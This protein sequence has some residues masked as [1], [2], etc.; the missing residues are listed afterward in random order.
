MLHSLC[1]VLLTGKMNWT[2]F[3]GTNRLAPKAVRC[4]V[5]HTAWSGLVSS[6]GMMPSVFQRF[7][8]SL[9]YWQREVYSPR[10]TSTGDQLKWF[11]M[12]K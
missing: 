3:G 1:F 7:S 12:L 2:E 11:V 5:K 9:K 8:C 6:S 10:V 4:W